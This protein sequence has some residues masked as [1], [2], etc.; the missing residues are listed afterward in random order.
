MQPGAKAVERE[1]KATV[2][3]VVDSKLAVL[4][5][6][7]SHSRSPRIHEAAYAELGLAW[8]YDAIDVS[9]GEFDAFISGRGS[10]WL[11]FSVTMPLKRKAFEISTTVD[12]AASATTSVNTL[13][14]LDNIWAGFNT[15]VPGIETCVMQ[16]KLTK[17]RSAVVL[18]AGATAASVIY[19]LGQMGFETIFVVARRRTQ[20]DELVSRFET[21]STS[22]RSVQLPTDSTDADR[23]LRL[24]TLIAGADLLINTLPG[25]VVSH[26]PLIES[27]APLPALFDISY[28]PWPSPLSARWDEAKVPY[29]HGLDLLVQQALLQV[30]IFVHGDAG[31]PLPR[32]EGVLRAMHLASMK[33]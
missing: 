21:A 12:A 20:A 17:M 27:L 3:R 11:G 19:A 31:I 14:R 33:E 5:S 15:D 18:G 24:Q 9:E 30:R 13:K 23:S 10:E 4:G 32:E 6:P 22:I 16:L 1:G 8:S 7:I 26:F 25:E 28:D 29:V 2:S